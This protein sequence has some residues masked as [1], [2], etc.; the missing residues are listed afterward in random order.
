MA[1]NYPLYPVIS[2]DGT[3]E[4]LQQFQVAITEMTGFLSYG[5]SGEYLKA[6]G[7][8]VFTFAT[9]SGAGT[10]GGLIVTGKLL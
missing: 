4:R 3:V 7:N 6:M 5:N 10:D 2:G 9:V 8:G 1:P